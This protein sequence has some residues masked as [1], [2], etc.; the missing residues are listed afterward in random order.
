MNFMKVIYFLIENGKE[1][2]E[3]I[4]ILIDFFTAMKER[5]EEGSSVALDSES[6]VAEVLENH[7]DFIA[8]CD[9]CEPAR[10]SPQDRARTH[11]FLR[12]LL[13]TLNPETIREYLELLIEFRDFFG[14]KT[15]ISEEI[16]KAT[17]EV[18]EPSE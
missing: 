17:S 16:E 7:P 8:L 14:L 1:F 6:V 11:G 12:D 2:K 4:D 3:Q 13:T 15:Q 10:M 5:W 18:E 9:Q